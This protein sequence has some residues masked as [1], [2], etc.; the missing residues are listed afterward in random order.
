[1]VEPYQERKVRQ[2]VLLTGQLVRSLNV[3][4]LEF[5]FFKDLKTLESLYNEHGIVSVCV[6]DYIF[7]E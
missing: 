3:H 5:S 6:Y 7:K 2:F 1:M 4:E